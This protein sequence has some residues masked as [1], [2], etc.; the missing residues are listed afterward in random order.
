MADRTP[1]AAGEY[2]EH[3]LQKLEVFIEFR[4]WG[5]HEHVMVT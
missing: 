4:T 2:A 3:L 1:G 5:E